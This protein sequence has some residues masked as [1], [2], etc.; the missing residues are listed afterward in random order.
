M[1]SRT[2]RSFGRQLFSRR[3]SVFLTAGAYRGIV[4]AA[5]LRHGRSRMRFSKPPTNQG[6]I[7]SRLRARSGRVKTIPRIVFSHAPVRIPDLTS[8]TKKRLKG[9]SLFLSLGYGKDGF[10]FL[11]DG[12][13]LTEMMDRGFEGSKIPS[14]RYL[15]TLTF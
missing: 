7:R 6:G 15:S 13:E 5:I 3:E 12:F 8:K 1:S 4:S 9:V 11:M 14:N 2:P 10:A